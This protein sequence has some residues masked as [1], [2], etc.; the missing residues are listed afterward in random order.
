MPFTDF[1]KAF[2][3]VNHSILLN[4]LSFGVGDPLL[5]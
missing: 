2:N 4:K 1:T 3:T 5:N